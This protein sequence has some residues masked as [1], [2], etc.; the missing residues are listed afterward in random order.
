MTARLLLLNMFFIV[1][2]SAASLSPPPTP[3][4]NM[5]SNGKHADGGFRTTTGY[6][7]ERGI[8]YVYI[9]IYI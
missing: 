8:V 3:S 6:P 5:P 9:Y 2:S 7:E 1:S 4:P